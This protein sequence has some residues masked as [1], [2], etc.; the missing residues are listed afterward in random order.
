MT[1][2][3]PSDAPTRTELHL[4]IEAV[5]KLLEAFIAALAIDSE[6]TYGKPYAEHV[7]LVAETVVV[8][9]RSPHVIEEAERI[10]RESAADRVATRV[11]ALDRKASLAP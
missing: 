2:P 5:E 4:E 8:A 9:L 11:R 10:T 3:V 6:R 1:Y 7:R